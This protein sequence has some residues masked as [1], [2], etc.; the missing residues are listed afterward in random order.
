MRYG[1]IDRHR[2]QYPVTMMCGALRVSRSGYYAWRSRPECAR[3]I[4]DR[5]LTLSIQQIHRNSRA[6]YG[7]VKIREELKAQGQC[8]GRHKIARLM[9]L[10]GLKGCPSKRF[11][12]TT[13]PIPQHTQADI[14]I[15]V[16]EH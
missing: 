9:R 5:S 6:V 7:A 1:C 11:N 2:E 14:R 16:S 4:T 8:Y 10:A 13:Q 15:L 12:V 3:A